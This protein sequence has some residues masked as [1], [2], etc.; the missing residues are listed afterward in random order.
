MEKQEQTHIMRYQQERG[1]T[2]SSNICPPQ[3]EDAGTPEDPEKVTRELSTR[4][5]NEGPGDRA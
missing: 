1:P 3:L 5:K 2:E 4:R